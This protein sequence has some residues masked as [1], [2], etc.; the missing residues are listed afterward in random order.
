MQLGPADAHIRSGY[1][2]TNVTDIARFAW[3]GGFREPELRLL[4]T[5]NLQAITDAVTAGNSQSFGYDNLQRLNQASALRRFG[6]TY[7]GMETS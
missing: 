4:S 6:F 2:L 7:T 3:L 1:R 5:N